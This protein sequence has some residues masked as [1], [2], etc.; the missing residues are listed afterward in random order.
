MIVALGASVVACSAQPA[1]PGTPVL[2]STFGNAPWNRPV[3]AMAAH[4]RSDEFS[5]RLFNYSNLGGV[6]DPKLKGRFSTYFGAYSQPVYDAREATGTIRV[7]R[8][9]FGYQGSIAAGGSIPWND[10]WQPPDGN[11]RTMYII[12]PR[13]GREWDLWLVQTENKTTCLTFENL[14]LGFSMDDRNL[15]VGQ[16]DI[17]QDSQGDPIDYRTYE[18][19][20]PTGGAFIQGLAM[21]TT[22][23]E[24]ANGAIPHAL[25][26]VVYNTMFGPECTAAERNTP[27]AGLDCGFFEFPAGHLERA[28][29]PQDCGA[30]TLQHTNA[31]R[32]KTVPQGI[33]FA[34]RVSDAQIESW[35]DSR[36]YA[37]VLRNT[38][39]VFAVAA[40]DYG[41][42]I[43]NTSCWDAGFIT[44]G[45]FNP[46]TRKVWESLGVTDAADVSL[47]HGLFTAT[48]L[49]AVVPS[50]PLPLGSNAV[51]G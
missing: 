12:D 29:G 16:A 47:L 1:V 37:G 25:N 6:T 14:A 2:G 21:L 35:L 13:T 48:N 40:R 9:G 49:W 23:D 45:V 3:A 5:T 34:V 38:A 32:A 18:G 17:V 19:A 28:A 42:V 36:G 39:R 51:A 24:V 33:R 46:A 41:F 27:A 11:D 7:F 10:S 8:A 22:A 20:Y 15:C 50:E 30:S 31:D 26:A 43:T 44:D 4:P